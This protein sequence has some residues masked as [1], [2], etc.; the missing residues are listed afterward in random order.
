MV[1]RLIDD[2]PANAPGTCIIG[3]PDIVG[4]WIPVGGY[5][6]CNLGRPRLSFREPPHCFQFLTTW[7]RVHSR[8]ELV[9][10]YFAGSRGDAGVTVVLRS[11]HR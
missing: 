6:I 9:I 3:L 11:W 4:E 10:D 5:F 8:F 1:S 2:V 7:F